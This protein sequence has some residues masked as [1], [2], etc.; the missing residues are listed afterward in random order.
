[1]QKQKNSQFSYKRRLLK[2]TFVTLL[3]TSSIIAFSNG[4]LALTYY[5]LPETSDP[6]ILSGFAMNTHKLDDLCIHTYWLHPNL[7]I[8]ALRVKI[9][10][11]DEI[12]P[13]N[14]IHVIHNHDKTKIYD[15]G[16]LTQDYVCTNYFD[17][18]EGKHSIQFY[19][20]TVS[21]N[22]QSMSGHFY[23]DT[24]GYLDIQMMERWSKHDNF[25]LMRHPNDS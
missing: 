13:L 6:L 9:V 23:T 20:Y 16:F 25:I 19:V 24:N 5:D 1:M 10:V 2:I 22:Y 15:T 3:I 4:Y 11:N 8:S 21:N 12:A 18:K 7:I 14:S 17:L